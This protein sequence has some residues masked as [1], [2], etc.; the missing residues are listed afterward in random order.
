M[1]RKIVSLK[2][3]NLQEL[4]ILCRTCLHWEGLQGS[5]LDLDVKEAESLK[6]ARLKSILSEWGE[7]GVLIL[8]DGEPLGYACYGP[9]EH[10]PKVREYRTGPVSKD[11]I[12]LACLYVSPRGRG[13]SMGR[14]L[15]QAVQK[16][17]YKKN[18]KAIETFANK[19]PDEAPSSPV[20]FYLKN[21][22]YILRDDREFPLMRLDI[23]A[24]VPWQE[25][26]EAALDSLTLPLKRKAVKKAPVP[27]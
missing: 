4:P 24:L 22:F 7:C 25:S 27:L 8:E 17:L 11:A 6:I 26:V 20:E 5:E 3:N 1:G 15:L 18:F 14:Q 10:F 19:T 12:F 9:S 23:K 13:K 21:G 16:N 2:E